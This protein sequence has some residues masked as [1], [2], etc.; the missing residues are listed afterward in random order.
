MESPAPYFSV[1]ACTVAQW[2]PSSMH[3]CLRFLPVHFSRESLCRLWY[4]AAS[5]VAPKRLRRYGILLRNNMAAFIHVFM[6]IKNDDIIFVPSN[7]RQEIFTLY[8][9]CSLICY[10]IYTLFSNLCQYCRIYQ[11]CKA[12]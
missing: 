8:V 12:F 11:P 9:M 5:E 2:T 6:A 4:R 3:T 7:H 10:K 1:P